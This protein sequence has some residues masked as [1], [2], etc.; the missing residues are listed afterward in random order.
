MLHA[1]AALP[2]ITKHEVLQPPVAPTADD[3]G[4]ETDLQ[5]R[6]RLHL[7]DQVVRHPGVERSGKL[8]RAP[9]TPAFK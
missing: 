2:V 6:R 3:L 1:G 9:N 4:L 7:A 5:I 8:Q